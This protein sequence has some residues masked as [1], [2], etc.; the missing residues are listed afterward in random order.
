MSAWR[1]SAFLIGLI[2]I[3]YDERLPYV[4]NRG[5]SKLKATTVHMTISQQQQI[6]PDQLAEFEQIILSSCE[7][8]GYRIK[9]ADQKIQTFECDAPDL[10]VQMILAMVL[11][12]TNE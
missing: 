4:Q 12:S 7:P 6:G 1:I 9:D 2:E 5:F 8:N 10:L 11:H 3:W